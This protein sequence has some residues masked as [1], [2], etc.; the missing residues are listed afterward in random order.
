MAARKKYPIPAINGVI[1][2]SIAEAA[3]QFGI[4]Y[5]AMVSHVVKHRKTGEPI[6]V[7]KRIPRG[8][9]GYIDGVYYP[10]IRAARK[11][12]GLQFDDI[13]ALMSERPSQKATRLRSRK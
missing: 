11:S 4:G 7:E 2:P 3:R 1:Y 5:S 12:L 9:H 13:K 6:S 10:S 8:H